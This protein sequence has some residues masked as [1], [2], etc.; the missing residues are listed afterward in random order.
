MRH[1]E[2]KF[3]WAQEA[4]SKGRVRIKKIPGYHNPADILT[5]PKERHELGRLLANVGA[6]YEASR[7]PQYPWAT[8]MRRRGNPLSLILIV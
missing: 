1:V 2:L 4:V 6:H 8:V 5:K 7:S 3:L